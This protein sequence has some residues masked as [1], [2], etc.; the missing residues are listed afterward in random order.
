MKRLLLTFKEQVSPL[1]KLVII[2][3]AL[4][5]VVLI[6]S[7]VGWIVSLK[8][9]RRIEKLESKVTEQTEELE[10]KRARVLE[11]ESEITQ[12]NL[13][14]AKLVAIKD[15]AGQQAKAAEKEVEDV[16]KQIEADIARTGEPVDDDTR[17]RRI[18][19]R[20]AERQKAK[21]K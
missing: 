1:G 21:A 10:Q 6:A 15:A 11:L 14:R 13:E 7:G 16:E 20:L 17:I 2:G 8:E 9:S 5:I 19:E 18:R 12:L 4:L 3:G